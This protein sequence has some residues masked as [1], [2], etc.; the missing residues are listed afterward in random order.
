MSSFVDLVMHQNASDFR[1]EFETKMQE[2][3]ASALEDE[4]IR[5][6]SSLFQTVGE[7]DNEE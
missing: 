3:V 6:A 2:K 1:T 7:S 5:I 4:K